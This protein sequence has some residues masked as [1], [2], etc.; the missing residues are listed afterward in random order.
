LLVWEKKSGKN[1]NIT[2]YFLAFPYLDWNPVPVVTGTGPAFVKSP[3]YHTCAD[4]F[5]ERTDFRLGKIVFLSFFIIFL[6]SCMKVMID[7][8]YCFGVGNPGNC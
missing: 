7:Y 2:V 1:G 3:T 6:Y 8:L 5:A 4:F